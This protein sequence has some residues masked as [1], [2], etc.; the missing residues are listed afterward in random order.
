MYKY[1]LFDLDGTLINP[2]E[3]I[4]K[5]V[6]Y[7]L[8]KM[9]IDEPNLDKLETFIGPPL[10]DSFMQ[11]YDMTLEEAKQATVY[12]R[13]RFSV[14]GVKEN[15]LLDDCKEVLEALHPHYTLAI[16]TSKPENFALEILKQHNLFD[17]FDKVCGA[18]LEGTR[19][20]KQDVIA[21]ALK[22]LE[23][24][25]LTQVLMIGD[26]KHDIIGAKL[27]NI[28]SCGLYCGFAPSNE[29]EEH[30]ATYIY[31]NLSGL[32]ELLLKGE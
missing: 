5:S 29:L 25:D 2:K 18:N 4:T 27:N 20:K 19:S 10:I 17:Y 23:V 31:D 8:T 12:Y 6:Q 9:G 14:K 16:A 3:G 26:R 24:N 21:Y 13:E 11:E 1:L 30:G 28:D 32:K 7:A 15:L 22:E